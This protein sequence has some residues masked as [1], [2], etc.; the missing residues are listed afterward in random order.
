MTGDQSRTLRVGDRVCW[1]DQPGT[2][3]ERNWAGIIVKWDSRK[4]QSL[5]HNDMGPVERVK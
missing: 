2:V 4:E 3:T 1:G 5:L